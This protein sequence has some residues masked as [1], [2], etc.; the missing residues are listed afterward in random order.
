LI[1]IGG[2]GGK[3]KKAVA[4][5]EGIK[6]ELTMR[7]DLLEAKLN[8]DISKLREENKALSAEIRGLRAELKK[9]GLNAASE[10]NKPQGGKKAKA[11]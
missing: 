11:R 1:V 8:G 6:T 5:A 7:L 2:G 10:A 3:D 9:A 4:V